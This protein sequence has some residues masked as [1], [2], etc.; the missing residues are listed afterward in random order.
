[1]SKAISPR[2]LTATLAAVVVS[3]T[4]LGGT[5]PTLAQ[6]KKP[7]I[8]FIMGDDIG[9]MQVGAYHQGWA[10]GETQTSTASP[11]RAGSSQTTTPCRVAPP[12]GTSSSRACT[13]CGRA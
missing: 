5:S 3:L 2:R 6:E 10:L 12:G 9:L 11:K 1:M 8:L 4:A 13:P 7:N